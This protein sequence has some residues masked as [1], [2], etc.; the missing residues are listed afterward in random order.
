MVRQIADVKLAGAGLP[1]TIRN[2]A[3][4]YAPGK[5]RK[6]EKENDTE[7]YVRDISSASG[8]DADAALDRNNAD[9]MSGLLKAIVRFE[10]GAPHSEWFTDDE[11][12]QAALAMQEGA[13]D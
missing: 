12:R 7:K 2:W 4:V 13:V 11:Y 1:F 8:L 10:S 3:N 6:G 5:N 9:E